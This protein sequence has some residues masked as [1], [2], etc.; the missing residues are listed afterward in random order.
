MFEKAKP[1]PREVSGHEID[2]EM[3]VG[4]LDVA[5]VQTGGALRAVEWGEL[6]AKLEAARDLRR[7]LR[8]DSRLNIEGGASSFGDAAAS[9][10]SAL[11]QS[12]RTVNPDALEQRK[13]S[14]AIG[15]EPRCETQGEA[16][17]EAATGDTRD[18]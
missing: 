14:N 7:V 4:S 16:Q 1:F 5:P 9:Y 2:G 8:R 12:Q 17:G 13:A 11:E 18:D 10:F 3:L 6:R 15:C